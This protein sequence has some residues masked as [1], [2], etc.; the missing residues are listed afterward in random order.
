MS[1]IPFFSYKHPDK[2]ILHLVDVYPEKWQ[3]ATLTSTKLPP[4]QERKMLNRMYSKN[5]NY[6]YDGFD[7]DHYIFVKK[8]M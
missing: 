5:G 7:L 4:A 6:R 8:H 1:T 2:N 3:L